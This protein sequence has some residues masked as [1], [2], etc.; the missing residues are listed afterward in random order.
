MLILV[1]ALDWGL[2]HATRV[3]PVIHKLLNEGHHV[4][5]GASHRQAMIYNEHFPA[6]Q[7]E[8]LPAVSPT[9]RKGQN[10]VASILFF[11]PRFLISIKKDKLIARKLV[12]KYKPD[13]IISDNRYG[14]RN[15]DTH[16]IIISHQ[17]N[18]Q[19]P[20]RVKIFRK[21]I[22]ASIHRFLNRFDEC[23]IPDFEDEDNLSGILSHSLPKLNC[24]ITYTG[25]LSR[26]QI[27]QEDETTK[28]FP[29]LLVIISGPEQQR[30]FFENI[31]RQELVKTG[32]VPDYV[33]VRGLPGQDSTGNEHWLNHANASTLKAFIRNAKYIV[34]RSGYSTI[35]DLA[36]MGKTAMLVPTPGQTEQEY[37][38]GY[39]QDKGK[40]LYS[41][42]K[43]F[44]LR[45][46]LARLDNFILT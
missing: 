11:L 9:F 25:L 7:M 42:Q 38:A 14:F 21:F 32:N 34:C 8:E 19:V 24:K 43:H 16:N 35:M 10:Q 12:A 17:V 4:I 2:G 36:V 15:K 22:Q 39:L 6:V 41:E 33:V 45:E 28:K 29:Q 5:I 37:L 30:T 1:G 44:N 18:L 46:C 13:Q 20:K 26:L 40:F 31:I 27:V 3:V 23:Y